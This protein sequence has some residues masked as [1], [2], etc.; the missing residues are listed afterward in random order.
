M[1]VGSTIMQGNVWVRD[2][3]HLCLLP[4]AVWTALRTLSFRY[5][6]LIAVACRSPFCLRHRRHQ[7]LRACSPAG[8]G[9][10]RLCERHVQGMHAF[11]ADDID[12]SGKRR[13]D[14]G[15][16]DGEAAV[17]ELLDDEGR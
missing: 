2:L 15:D 7:V 9:L 3:P 13:G 11:A 6:S 4:P 1:G 5:V 10:D 17:F 12:G 14:R 16:E 8:D